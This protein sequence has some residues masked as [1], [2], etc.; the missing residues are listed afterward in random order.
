MMKKHRRT[1]AV[2]VIL[3]LWVGVLAWLWWTGAHGRAQ[4]TQVSK[5]T[6]RIVYVT[7]TGDHYHR[8]GCDYLRKSRIPM[9]IDEAEKRYL[10]CSKCRPGHSTAWRT[11]T[12]R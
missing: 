7:K 8:S 2:A 4:E 5:P 1:I 10:P 12:A 11:D 9:P 6:E 3:T